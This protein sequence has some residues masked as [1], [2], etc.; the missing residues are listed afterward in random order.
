[1]ITAGSLAA[2]SAAPAVARLPPGMPAGSVVPVREQVPAAPVRAL[3]GGKLP[4]PPQPG[5]RLPRGSLLDL[6]I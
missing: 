5:Q 4:G 3:P 1:M 6:Q 2:F